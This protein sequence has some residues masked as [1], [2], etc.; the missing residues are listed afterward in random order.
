MRHQHQHQQQREQTWGLGE[1]S[2]ERG[3][4]RSAE[5]GVEIHEEE[6]EE[7]EEEGQEG[8]TVGLVSS[9]PPSAPS[10][11]SSSSSSAPAAAALPLQAQQQVAAAD[12]AADHAA[13]GAAAEGALAS[14]LRLLR[15][16]IV[17]GAVGLYTAMGSVGIVTQELFPLYSINPPSR[18]GFDL[19]AA[20]L[21]LLNVAAG[22]P[23]LLFQLL[24]FPVLSRRFGVVALQTHSLG[25]SALAVALTPLLSLASGS[26]LLMPAVY[27]YYIAATLVR[28]CGFVA[29]FVVVANSAPHALDRAKVC[30]GGG[31]GGGAPTRQSAALFTRQPH[32]SLV[33][34][35][36]LCTRSRTRAAQQW[37]GAGASVRGARSVPCAGDAAVCAERERRQHGGGVAL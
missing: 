26:P 29:N 27:S 32:P 17:F 1:G 9:P 37:P 18:G 24:L 30:V 13:A 12:R 22:V 19:T 36:R 5:G 16:P 7:E 20:D 2:E 6:E 15:D 28:V 34:P 4:K 8:E 14:Y 31:G 21:G 25:W 23:L 33:F 3:V 10:G 11:S 35:L